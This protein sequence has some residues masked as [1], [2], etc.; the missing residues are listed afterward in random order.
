[1]IPKRIVTD[2]GWQ[3]AVYDTAT[4]T[5]DL[6]RSEAYQNAFEGEGFAV[7]AL[8]Q[9]K[10]R[11]RQGRFWH[12]EKNDG[13]Y[14]SLRL[15]PKRPIHDW[16]TLSFVVGLSLLQAV[17]ERFPSLNL[18]LKWPNDLLIDRQKLSGI[19]L[20]AQG[21]DV[22]IGC[23]VNLKNAPR[24]TEANFPPTDLQAQTGMLIAPEELAKLFLRHCHDN[25]QIWQKAGFSALYDLYKA[26]VLFLSEPIT[27]TQSGQALS[28]V[29]EDI[30]KDGTLLLRGDDG[31]LH[32]VTTG[33]VNLMG[34][35]NASGN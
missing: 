34:Y 9:T 7:L 25:Y 29:M 33:D 31:Q 16:P 19:L 8:E 30:T 4:S 15:H 11:G 18:G 27:V 26:K 21:D 13:M 20:E 17:S 1:M 32:N 2:F 3:L 14:L 6:I 28:G 23:G 5:S 35:H 10:G 12:S 22:I 24:V